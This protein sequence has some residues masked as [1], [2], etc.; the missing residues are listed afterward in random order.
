MA[1]N[2]ANK[3]IYISARTLKTVLVCR[4][5]GEKSCD[6]LTEAFLHRK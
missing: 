4:I 6:A 5:K 1:T 3:A 2:N